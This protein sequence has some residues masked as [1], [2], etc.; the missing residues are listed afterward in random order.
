MVTES[1]SGGELSCR[2]IE[3]NPFGVKF[4]TDWSGSCLR[5]SMVVRRR[6]ASQDEC[7]GTE[8]TLRMENAGLPAGAGH[9]LARPIGDA[10]PLATPAAVAVPRTTPAAATALPGLAFSQILF[11]C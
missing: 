9:F 8:A 1:C 2:V 6:S 10:S 11:R 7:F 3:T 4:R 5:I